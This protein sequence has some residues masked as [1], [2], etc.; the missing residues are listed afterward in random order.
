MLTI[1]T[2]FGFLSAYPSTVFIMIHDITLYAVMTDKY[3]TCLPC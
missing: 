3:I 2:L 1:A